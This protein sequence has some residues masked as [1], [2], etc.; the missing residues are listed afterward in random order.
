MAHLYVGNPARLDPTLRLA[1]ATLPDDYWVFAEFSIDRN[2]DCFICRAA[3]PD[4]AHTSTLIAL[5]LKCLAQP[6][7]GDVDG[8]WEHRDDSGAW[9]PLPPA[10]ARAIN[11]YRQAVDAAEAVTAYLW[12]QQPRYR[13]GATLPRQAYRV[14][15]DLLLLSPEGVMHQLPLRPRTGYGHWYTRLDP[16][17]AH[18][19]AWTS[20]AEVR[21]SSTEL[22]ALAALLGLQKVQSAPQPAPSPNDSLTPLSAKLV[23][24]EQ[25]LA[26]LEQCLAAFEGPSPAPATPATTAPR[27]RPIDATTAPGRQSGATLLPFR[28]PTLS[29]PAPTVRTMTTIDRALTDT[30]RLALVTALTG[31]T[32]PAVVPAVVDAMNGVLG[33]CLKERAYNGFGS[34]T[35]LLARARAEGLVT[36][37]P[38]HGTQT[39]V[40]LTPQGQALTGLKQHGA[41]FSLDRRN[42]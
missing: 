15:P 17:L 10:T 33:Y 26:A 39:T 20:R 34:A 16:W 4:A 6:V 31:L 28:P 13:Q 14:W 37:G 7:R 5:E 30:E 2:I 3:E 23:A 41:F 25:R 22:A 32:A 8:P 35:V 9:V 11:P 29:A 18:V 1:L 36:D 19:Q 38:P 42:G 12:N 24:F 27:P 21:L 40:A